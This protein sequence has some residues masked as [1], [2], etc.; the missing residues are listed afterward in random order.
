[1]TDTGNSIA[2]GVPMTLEQMRVYLQGMFGRPV[3]LREQGTTTVG[4]PYC[5]ETHDHGAQAGYH[6]PSCE[7]DEEVENILVINDREYKKNYGYTIYEFK[8]NGGR[9]YELII[10]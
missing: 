3:V 10:D 9:S 2:D 4:C 8:S 6:V 7:E 5:L 1:M